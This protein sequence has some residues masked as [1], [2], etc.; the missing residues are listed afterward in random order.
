M[1]AHPDCYGTLFPDFTRLQKNKP[2][3]SQA[4]TAL[5]VSHGIGVQEHKLEV[6]RDGWKKCTACPDYRTCC[7]LSMAQL[8]MNTMLT[9]GWYG[10]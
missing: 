4:F 8:L 10:A 3:E 9:N 2:L 6:K 7:D 1:S 5:V